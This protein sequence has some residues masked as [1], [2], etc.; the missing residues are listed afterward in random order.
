M[1]IKSVIG[2]IVT[3]TCVLFPV[4]QAKAIPGCSLYWEGAATFFGIGGSVQVINADGSG[5]AVSQSNFISG[6]H[7]PIQNGANLYVWRPDGLGCST[8]INWGDVY[9]CPCGYCGTGS[10]Y[11][12]GY[13]VSWEVYSGYI[14]CSCPSGA[15]GGIASTTVVHCK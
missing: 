11:S 13:N 14:Y 5:Y 2:L 3:L 7:Y 4:S 6:E 10:P 12:L 8:V 15:T 9:W 1:K